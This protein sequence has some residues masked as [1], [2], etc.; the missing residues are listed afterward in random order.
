MINVQELLHSF[1]NGGGGEENNYQWIEINNPFMIQDGQLEVDQSENNVPTKD[2]FVSSILAITST[3]IGEP[4]SPGVFVITSNT[5]T[6]LPIRSPAMYHVDH[7]TGFTYTSSINSTL[8]KIDSNTSYISAAYYAG[9]IMIFTLY[10]GLII[11]DVQASMTAKN[12]F[13]VVQRESS[14]TE[15]TTASMHTPAFTMHYITDTSCV[16]HYIYLVPD[17]VLWQLFDWLKIYFTT[18]H[19]QPNPP[20]YTSVT[21]FYTKRH[22]NMLSTT[23]DIGGVDG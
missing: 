7:Y 8:S 20:Y 11:T 22:G 23:S 2:I 6:T 1:D 18:N 3:T 10:I 12:I 14:D 5:T 17:T 9:S 19:E 15:V 13:V 21:V 16:I 4:S